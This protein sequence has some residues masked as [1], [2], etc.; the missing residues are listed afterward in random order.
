MRGDGAVGCS[1][2]VRP[3]CGPVAAVCVAVEAYERAERGVEPHG[4]HRSQARQGGR[5]GGA[6]V[7]RQH[8]RNDVAGRRLYRNVARAVDARP[9]R[10]S[11]R[12]RQPPRRAPLRSCYVARTVERRAVHLTRRLQP[13]RRRSVAAYAYA[14]RAA[15][16]AAGLGRGVGDAVSRQRR[17][18]RRQRGERVRMARRVERRRLARNL[19]PGWP[20]RH[21]CRRSGREK[22]APCGV[23]ARLQH[24]LPRGVQVPY[25]LQPGSLPPR[26][27]LSGRYGQVRGVDV[28]RA[29]IR[30]H[31]VV[32]VPVEVGRPVRLGVI[33]RRQNLCYYVPQVVGEHRQGA[34]GVTVLRD[35]VAHQGLA[36]GEAEAYETVQGPGVHRRRAL[37]PRAPARV[38]APQGGA[39]PFHLVEQALAQVRGQGRRLGRRRGVAVPVLQQ[40]VSSPAAR[41]SAG[42][43]A[44]GRHETGRVEPGAQPVLPIHLQAA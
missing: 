19:V 10:H 22:A 16:P 24:G 8:A 25:V 20:A 42:A 30:V 38:D 36:G 39:E 28:V 14:P 41:A 31:R 17:G 12:E 27:P 5:H 21:V 26:R 15:R 37:E 44:E 32:H 9:A 29:V 4:R 7:E 43:C 23:H 35:G 40:P 33:V 11:A 18:L 6:P 2:R 3:A 13:R 1:G 34:H